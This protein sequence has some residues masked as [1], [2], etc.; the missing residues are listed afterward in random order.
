MNSMPASIPLHRRHN[1]SGAIEAIEQ[2]YS[3]FH[4]KL[5]PQVFVLQ[6]N[7]AFRSQCSELYKRGYKDWMILGA[8]FNFL[9]QAELAER[10]VDI[11]D[12]QRASEIA[13]KLLDDQSFVFGAT[14][15]QELCGD[16]FLRFLYT[17]NMVALA[18][19]GFELRQ[20]VI[21]PEVMERF[22]RE[23]LDYFSLDLPHLPLFGDPPGNWPETSVQ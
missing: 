12:G 10:E 15:A 5:E 6:R 4:Q 16:Q 7:A 23:R 14:D 11:R 22:L 17:F 1:S 18:S 8:V 2:R 3:Q 9:L 13:R 19:Y 21:H 20:H